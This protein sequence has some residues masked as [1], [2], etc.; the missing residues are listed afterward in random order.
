MVHEAFSRP[1]TG[2][3]LAPLLLTFLF[4]G[5]GWFIIIRPQQERART[6]RAMV[7]TL[8]AGDRVITAGGIHGT[9][10]DLS[11]DTVELEV[12]VGVVLTL[13]RPAVA[14]RLDT[15]PGAEPGAGADDPNLDGP[16]AGGP[17]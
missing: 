5:I 4:I 13:A 1:P 14:R 16:I 3:S 10:I 17:A 2:F 9:V 12:A 11:E 15:E 8:A 6:Q 7:A